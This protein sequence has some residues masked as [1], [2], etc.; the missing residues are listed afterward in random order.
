MNIRN[1]TKTYN[2]QLV[3]DHIHFV[4]GEGEMVAI[5]GPSG[6]GK[7]VLLKSLALKEKWDAGA[8]IYQ[9]KDLFKS[10]L[11]HKL[12]FK[13][14]L[15]F[16]PPRE[17]NLNPNK[18]ALKNVL[19]SLLP[20]WRKLLGVRSRDEYMTAMDYLQNVGL[21]DLADRKISSLSGGEKKRVAIAKALIQ[22][23]ELIIAD[24]PVIG[25]DPHSAQQ[26]LKDLRYMVDKHKVTVMFTIPQID[27]A[28]QYATRIIGLVDG[29]VQFDVSG[30][31]LTSFE[32]NKI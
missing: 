3:L 16:L 12:R 14:K 29:Q 20:K 2:E 15:T 13:S 8:Y 32:K 25:L 22:G 18:T 6:S 27:W 9:E 30:R 10:G 21:L 17:L 31:R 28:E 4:V 19:V 23:A 11:L 1:L 26:V 7:S 5:V 24:E